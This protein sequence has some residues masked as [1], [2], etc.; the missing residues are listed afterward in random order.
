VA[1]RRLGPLPAVV[2]VTLAVMGTCS[3]CSLAPDAA[4][5]AEAAQAFHRAV[6]DGDGG[7]AC[8]LLSVPA[9]EELERSTGQPCPVAVLDEQLPAASATRDVA[10]YVRT[11]RVELDRD[12]VFVSMFGDEWRV[13]AA[14]CV[15]QSGDSY[16]CSV[17]GS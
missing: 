11:A 3:A 9:A 12:V 15:R 7:T 14:G 13:T 8:E 2:T 5:G 16:D 1:T 6:A 4:A 17:K 10:A